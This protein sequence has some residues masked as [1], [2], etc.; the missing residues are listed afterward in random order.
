MNIPAFAKPNHGLNYPSNVDELSTPQ[1]IHYLLLLWK[2]E[3]LEISL[4]EFK[5]LWFQYLSGNMGQSE[6]LDTPQIEDHIEGFFTLSRDGE[7]PDTFSL[8]NKLT[9]FTWKGETYTGP[10]DMCFN[11]S[12]GTFLSACH[13]YKDYTLTHNPMALRYLF[14][15][16]YSNKKPLEERA[17]HLSEMPL[18]AALSAYYFYKS[19]M[20]HLAT[21]P[22]TFQN[23]TLPLFEVFAS[24]NCQSAMGGL[25]T[26]AY[27]KAF[28]PENMGAHFDQ[29]KGQNLYEV[30]R[31]MWFKG[32]A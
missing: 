5:Q 4:T 21:N 28:S 3:S 9:Q 17:E 31:Y 26:L 6:H 23:E 32:K 7:H 19:V 25:S 22:V 20:T 14:A 29:L 16:L 13:V 2:Y 12:F 30:L 27:E 11:L 15:I 24:S 1:W 18:H 10:Q 8:K